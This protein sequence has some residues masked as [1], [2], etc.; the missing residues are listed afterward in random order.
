MVKFID[1]LK[2][3]FK[4]MC[5]SGKLFRTNIP[6][7]EIYEL[8]LASFPTG[9]DPV[10]RSPDSTTH[11]CNNCS[12]FVRRYGNIVS[13]NENFEIVTLFSYS[14]F[15]GE[16]KE[17]AAKVDALI[18]TKIIENVFFETFTELNSLNYEKCNK[19]N[20][21][22]R[23]GIDKNF[24]VYN[25]TEASMY[26]VVKAGETY[27]FNHMHLDLPK[28]FVDDSG[29]SIE[30]IMSTY[31]DR[32]NV[33]KRSLDEIPLDVL[34]LVK[35]LINQGSLLDG[36]SHLHSVIEQIKHKEKYDEFTGSKE[37]WVWHAT[38]SMEERTGKFG[39]TLLGTLCYELAEG[40]DLNAACE[41]WNKRVDPANY[42]KASAPITKK[43]IEEAQKFVVE[44]G[45]LESFN[46]RLAVS[47][48][49]DVSEI[50]HINT[51]TA[52]IKPVT[53]FD[54]LKPTVKTP[55]SNNF[56]SV[57]EVAIEKF[58]KDILPGCTSV[59]LYLRN[60]H[61][62]NLVALTTAISKHSKPI[63]KLSNNFSWTFNG[64]LAG[65]SQL[66]EAVAARGGRVDG[67][68]RFSQSWN[69]I[70]RNE[71]LMDLHVFM[72]GANFSSEKTHNTYPRERRVGWNNRTDAHSGGI[73]D[74][75]YTN[76]APIGY[77]PVE[78]ITFP[79]LKRMPAGKYICRIHNWQLRGTTT[80]GGTA[81]IEF[82]GHVYEYEYPRLGHHEWV[83]VAEVTLDKGV[84]T[85]EHKLPCKAET[86]Q[87]L[88]GM[89]TNNF[90]K[91][92]LI[93][94]SPNHW[95]EQGVGN[96]H[97]FFMLENAVSDT[98]IRGFHNE[99]LLPDLLLHRKV[100]EVLGTQSMIP[101]TPGQLSGVGFNSTV[102]D[103]VI[104]KLTGSFN[105]V[106]KVKF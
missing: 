39:N 13:L 65:K 77:I 16:R 105:R 15:E 30:K 88:W 43:Q 85:I 67:V 51:T 76:Q 45:Y 66:R 47:T 72:P 5:S 75:D 60:S 79:D 90:H 91:V 87:E 53:I 78:N 36:T 27:T 103:E 54:T 23:L 59:E 64:N 37:N 18:K 40:K 97:Y 35:D 44:N 101:S 38:Y 80:G 1:G 7:K 104:L 68:F 9:T 94:L 29:L 50:K 24:K 31:R 4:T 61:Q 82:A 26:G 33:F 95:G 89:Q 34:V 12:N 8:Y 14:G 22:F 98:E 11:T 19:K 6:G 48:D 93:C 83:T 57:E 46:R 92:N 102:K 52:V 70:G 71:S 56:D 73:Q 62:G 69:N 3:H 74:V 106:I 32:F 86:S 63:F 17:V 96:K 42:M 41:S 99:N 20:S 81:E 55:V 28:V 25:E 49:I 84:F 2:E 21:T 10:F 58:M 100:M